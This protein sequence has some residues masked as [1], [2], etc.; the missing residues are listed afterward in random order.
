M[1]LTQKERCTERA[2][3]TQVTL[4]PYKYWV[5]EEKRN[6]GPFRGSWA[7]TRFEKLPKMAKAHWEKLR[8]RDVY[9]RILK[10]PRGQTPE[11]PLASSLTIPYFAWVAPKGSFWP[12]FGPRGVKGQSEN[13]NLAAMRKPQMKWLQPS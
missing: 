2:E 4:F 3:C 12:F 9:A 10:T 1:H 7:K 5:F 6:S 8:C 11:T 13:T